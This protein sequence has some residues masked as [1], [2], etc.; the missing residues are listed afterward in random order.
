MSG[1]IA[2]FVKT[3][4]LSPIKTRLAVSLGTD[5]AADF[6]LASARAVSAVIKA[7]SELDTIQGYFAVAEQEGLN[8]EYW[9]GLPCLWQGEGGL[10]ERMAQI[11]RALLDTHEFVILVG[12]DIPQMTAADLLKASAWLK[13]EEQARFAFGPSFDGGFWLFGGNCPVPLNIW[14]GVNYSMADTGAQFH[15]KIEGLGEVLSLAL[16]DDVDE[17]GDLQS[18][19]KALCELTEPL[20]EQTELI[21]FLDILSLTFGDNKVVNFSG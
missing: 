11:Y 14:T 12:A 19:R 2:I 21:R 17:P 4:G 9:D 6:H 5:P 20:Q 10:G 16:L 7:A 8:H 3:P 18:L 15:N 1:A 13:H